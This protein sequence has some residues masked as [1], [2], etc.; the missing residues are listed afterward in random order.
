MNKDL[1]KATNSQKILFCL[2]NDPFGDFLESEIQKATKISKSG[3]NYALRELVSAD[4]VFRAKRGKTFFYT[5]N[6]DDLVVRQ[7][8]IIETVSGLEKVLKLLK[9]LSSKII[10]FGSSSRGEDTPDSDIDLM[11]ISRNK[12]LVLSKLKDCKCKRKIQSVIDTNTGFAEKKS[13]DPVFY[14][15]VNKGIVLWDSRS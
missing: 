14:E 10:L 4:F 8:K 13:K 6:R 2:L 9:P 12:D 1:L 5:L 7:L 3:V 15:Q 11:I